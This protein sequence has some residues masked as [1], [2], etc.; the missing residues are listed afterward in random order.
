MKRFSRIA[1]TLAFVL[2]TSNG[3]AQNSSSDYY[4]ENIGTLKYIPSGSFINGV[5]N[6][7]ISSFRIAEAEITQKQYKQITGENP[8]RF[9]TDQNHENF[10]VEQVS[11]YEAMK[12]CNL[13]SIKESLT[14][15][16]SIKGNT[17]PAKWG[18]A[19]TQLGTEWDQVIFNS[20]ANGYYL[21]TQSE[22]EYASRANT[23]A[24][25]FWGDSDEYAI[26]SKYALIANTP[27]RNSD[28]PIAV[29][30]KLPNQF[31]LYDTAGNVW[32]WC[33]DWWGE[34]PR[35]ELL[36]PKGPVSGTSKIQRGGGWNG[37][38]GLSPL[39][40]AGNSPFL[41]LFNVGF[42]VARK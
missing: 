2:T 10:P 29:K 1:L 42:R 31:G 13:L 15:V 16:Y 19:P 7:K 8:S 39:T 22:W 21:P 25:Y 9:I 5:A 20:S 27:H 26:V 4:S 41:K 36:D 38:A 18:A 11:W 28:S 40:R 14:P 32:E 30:Q 6:V 3:F 34:L 35:E 12:F 17:D 24:K 37:D 23:R 33:W